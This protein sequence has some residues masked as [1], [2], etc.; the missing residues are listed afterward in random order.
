LA[1]TVTPTTAP[2]RVD[3]HKLAGPQ[4]GPDDD[5]G[6]G[7]V[8]DVNIAPADNP[9]SNDEDKRMCSGAADGLARDGRCSRDRL[10]ADVHVDRHSNE[11][12]LGHDLVGKAYRRRA[13]LR[14]HGLRDVAHRGSASLVEG[15]C[16]EDLRAHARA[17]SADIALVHLRGDAG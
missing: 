14:I 16:G 4:P 9:S 7:P 17:Q 11:D 13:G 3:R 6:R 15:A 1:R 5:E 12:L 10:D 8:V 2:L